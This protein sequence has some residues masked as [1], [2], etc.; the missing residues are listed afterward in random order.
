MRIYLPCTDADRDVLRRGAR[1]LR[2]GADRLVFAVTA[3]ARQSVTAD[4][5]DLEYE[6]QQEAAFIAL[7]AA[8]PLSRAAVLAADA[9]TADLGD[10]K[11][12]DGLYGVRTTRETELVLVSVHVTELTAQQNDASDTDPALLWF[13][14]SESARALRFLDGST[15]DTAAG[16]D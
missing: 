12:A 2:V 6:A 16:V 15:S 8:E 1:R 13:D 7:R 10:G 3:Q 5:E 11:D 4:E 14:L 9:A